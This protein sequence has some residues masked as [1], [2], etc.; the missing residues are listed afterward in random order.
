MLLC[1][2][3]L[4]FATPLP[5]DNIVSETFTTELN[6]TMRCRYSAEDPDI[7]RE[8]LE[9][10]L[11]LRYPYESLGFPLLEAGIRPGSFN[12]ILGSVL[13]N[14][15]TQEQR[16][17]E[18]QSRTPPPELEALHR[19]VLSLFERELR[20]GRIVAGFFR[21][22]DPDALA[23]GLSAAFDLTEAEEREISAMAGKLLQGR[24]DRELATLRDQFFT[25]HIM[26]DPHGRHYADAHRE[27]MKRHGVRVDCVCI[28]NC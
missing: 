26:T 5:A 6:E 14:L 25:R 23:K 17:A 3:T 9:A 24:P 21:D 19:S 12:G 2:Q 22:R 16:I 7:S 11:R 13:R 28:G 18:M 1:A 10:W 20:Y 27:F 15:S 8:I 4:I